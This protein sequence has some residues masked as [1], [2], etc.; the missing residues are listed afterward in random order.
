MMVGGPYQ[1]TVSFIGHA[2]AQYENI[3]LSLGKPYTLPVTLKETDL[4]LP[5]VEIISTRNALQDKSRSITIVRSEELGTL[6]T[7]SRSINDF[8]RLTPQSGWESSFSGRDGRYNNITFDGANFNNNYGLSSN[9]LPGGNAQPI[10]L[11]AISEISVN[12]TPYD[13]SQSNFTGATINAVTKSGSNN[14]TGTAYTFL[15][16]KSLTGNLVGDNTIANANTRSAQ[17]Y[18][19]SLGGA[20]IKNKLLF[21]INGEYERQMFPSNSWAPSTDGVADVARKISRTTISDMETVKNYLLEQHEYDPGR[22][23]SNN[24][25]S[26]NHKILARLDWNINKN[27]KLT[28]RYNDVLS[29]N[30]EEVNPNSAPRPRSSSNRNSLN[31]ITFSNSNYWFKNTVQSLT[32]ELNSRFGNKISNMLLVSYTRIRDTRDSYS[33]PFP[34]VDIYKDGDMY[35]SFGYELFTHNTDVTN[36]TLNFTDNVNIYLGKHK[37]TS[38]ISFNYLNFKN[39]YMRYGL[40]YYRYAS[41]EDFINNQKPIA[42]GLTYGYNGTDI[43]AFQLDFGMGALFV[44]DEWHIKDNFTVTAGIRMEMPFYMNQLPNNAAINDTLQFQNNETI[45]IDKW[46]KSN[47]LISPR[48]GF[49]WDIMNNQFVIMRG[50]TGIF[51]GLLPFVWFTNQPNDNGVIQ[52]TVELVGNAIPDNMRFEQDYH[53]QI[54]NYPSLFPMQAAMKVP[55]QISFVDRNFHLPQVWRSTLSFDVKLPFDMVFTAEGMYGKDINAIFQENINESE[56][57][58]IIKEG[59]LERDSWWNNGMMVNKIEP[60]ISYVMKLTNR[61][62]GYQYY[63]TGQLQ[64][65]FSYGLSGIVAYTF[66]CSKDL[67]ANYGS[68]SSSMWNNNTALNSLNDPQLSYSSYSIPHRVIGAATWRIESGK[69]LAFTVSLIYQGAAQGRYSYAYNGDINGDGNNADLMYIP[70]NINELHFID[71]PGMTADEQAVTFFEYMKNNKY[72]SAHQGEFAQRN[73]VV[74]PWVHRFDLKI[75]NDL[76]T[77]FGSNHKYSL[78]L[79][80]DVLNIGNLFNPNWGCY[81][82]HGLENNGK[83]RPLTFEGF[84]SDGTPQYSLNTSDIQSFKENSG[85]VKDVSTQSVWGAQMGLRFCF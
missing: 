18:G 64:K 1:I 59:D 76:I 4:Q 58:S 82:I 6:P 2:T 37:L 21:F 7:I 28:L 72:L 51:T 68:A 11:D 13:L 20:I 10:S 71:K 41:M 9:N 48:A 44:Q 56:P 42:F 65:D 14:F 35:M 78:Q 32:G 57:T 49:N 30:D 17:L 5:D 77:G 53:H 54:N 55:G 66:S 26:R 43:P 34:F 23:T 38:G 75:M 40:G 15:R 29:T 62:E 60:G 25:D 50:G 80:L 36:N 33:S 84:L 45:Q 46:P 69:H 12:I 47:L 27:H 81:Q 24:F 16:P 79:S 22:F 39:T 74:G 67:C 52:N 61:S 83:I 73:A 70:K 8:S 3:S 19:V 31:A 63:L 85:F